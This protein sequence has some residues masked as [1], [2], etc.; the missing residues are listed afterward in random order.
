MY[1]KTSCGNP[2]SRKQR[3]GDSNQKTASKPCISPLPRHRSVILSAARGEFMKCGHIQRRA[4]EE[5]R[6]LIRCHYLW[7]Y[8]HLE[9]SCP[10][11]SDG[12]GCAPG[13]RGTHRGSSALGYS[14][15]RSI[16]PPQG[17]CVAPPSDLCPLI[18][19]L[20]ISVPCLLFPLCSSYDSPYERSHPHPHR[21]HR[22]RPRR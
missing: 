10:A 6:N 13:A 11:L 17:S 22:L 15:T 5:P 20:S 16:E 1:A 12:T 7:N 19:V 2:K 3:S 14:N 9:P 4:V 21:C 8:F 18:S